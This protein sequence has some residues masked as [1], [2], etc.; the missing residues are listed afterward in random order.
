[1]SKWS[2]IQQEGYAIYYA[3]TSWEYLLRDR[4]F[5]VRS[6]HA[7][8]I[9]WMLTLQSYDFDIEHIAGKD[10]EVADGFSILCN[11][12]NEGGK[13]GSKRDF[14]DNERGE[15]DS[16]DPIGLINLLEVMYFTESPCM[17]PKG[18]SLCNPITLRFTWN[19]S[20]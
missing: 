12:V 15:W 2:T 17:I 13:R 5:L 16:S 1:M 11:D 14:T 9:R 6:D 4:K 7:N 8:V 3:I 10:N 18:L 20:Q 19:C